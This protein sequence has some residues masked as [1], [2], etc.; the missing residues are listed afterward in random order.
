MLIRNR[1]STIYINTH[2]PFNL[3]R[4]CVERAKA[5]QLKVY[6]D[7]RDP[8]WTGSEED[9]RFT[10]Q[11]MDELMGF[12]S[13]FMDRISLL[14]VLCDTWAVTISVMQ[15]LKLMSPPQSLRHLELHRMGNA[16][17]T[18]RLPPGPPQAF[19]SASKLFQG[20]P[21]EKLQAVTLNGVFTDFSTETFRNLRVLEMRKMPV[22]HMPSLKELAKV[23]EGSPLLERLAYNG[24]CAKLEALCEQGPYQDWKPIR[25]AQLRE[26]SIVNL[27]STYA[28]FAV[29]IIDAPEVRH[30]VIGNMTEPEDSMCFIRHLTGRFPKVTILTV[31]G[32]V[33]KDLGVNALWLSTMPLKY[34]KVARVPKELL[35]AL[36]FE[37]SDGSIPLSQLPLICPQLEACHITDW[38]SM[39]VSDVKSLLKTRREHGAPFRRLLLSSK[40][41]ESM[42]EGDRLWA[43]QTGVL[44]Q[45]P[46]GCRP[47]LHE[48]YGL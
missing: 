8:D 1:W 26:F 28:I 20:F 15:A 43:R 13:Q 44:N 32:V 48:R 12:L 31:E 29:K 19:L 36:A 21:V 38:H 14:V 9:N 30:L 18:F 35:G 40:D 11:D 7:Q 27:I 33:S 45:V 4:V 22:E 16:Y 3:A 39:D 24:A 2:P 41:L 34:L 47:E 46:P 5:H 42:S 10:P 6:V 23:L 17:V 37:E 25:M